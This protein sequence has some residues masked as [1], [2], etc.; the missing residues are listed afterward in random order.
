MKLNQRFTE[1]TSEAAT[2]KDFWSFL[3]FLVF[4]KTGLISVLIGRKDNGDGE[5]GYGKLHGYEANFCYFCVMETDFI[6]MDNNRVNLSLTAFYYQRDGKHVVECPS[7]RTAGIEDSHEE[8]LRMCLEMSQALVEE[9][10]INDTL[11][12]MLLNEGWIIVSDKNGT[13]RFRPPSVKP[14]NNTAL[15]EIIALSA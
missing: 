2:I 1:A 10:L 12:E 5:N 11:E 7:L 4:I 15:T 6:D 14:V 13:T 3:S 8:A 9:C